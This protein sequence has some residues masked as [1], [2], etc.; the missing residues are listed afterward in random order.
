[1]SDYSEIYD[2]YVG[3]C[4]GCDN[5]YTLCDCDGKDDEEYDDEACLG[6]QSTKNLECTNVEK[7]C[8]DCCSCTEHKD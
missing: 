8:T 1:M 6:C 7:Y 2:D 5:P 3:V 4:M